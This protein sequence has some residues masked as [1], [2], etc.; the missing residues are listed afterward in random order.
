MLIIAPTAHLNA[1]DNDQLPRFTHHPKYKQPVSILPSALAQCLLSRQYQTPERSNVDKL[2]IKLQE[3]FNQLGCVFGGAKNALHPA[4]GMANSPPAK[5]SLRPKTSPHAHTA[6]GANRGP[7]YDADHI[8]VWNLLG[9]AT[10]ND[11]LTGAYAWV[12]AA[13]CNPFS[14]PFVP[15]LGLDPAAFA[16]LLASRFPHFAPPQR[17]LALQSNPAGK[18]GAMREF[19]GLLQ[20]LLEH[21][22]YPDEHHRNV[23]HL[24]ATASMG[25]GLLWHDL[26]LP[27]QASLSA[28]FCWHFP[29]LA[30]KNSGNMQWK[31][32]F[33]QQ[34]CEREGLA[35]CISAT[36]G[37]SL[38]YPGSIGMDAV[39]AHC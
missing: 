33:Y 1:V 28:L 36:H 27:D 20:L 37:K 3:M 24:I 30:E 11:L 16:D 8:G 15:A 4:S 13:R 21:R 10:C 31:T 34:L 14:R 26:G 23:A 39:E 17:W 2:S 32:F 19:P 38:Y 29:D 9:Q 6:S 18:D 22:A 7:A 5:P 12:I 35:A 25:D